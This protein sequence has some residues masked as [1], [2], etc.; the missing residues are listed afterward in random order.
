M[1]LILLVLVFAPSWSFQYWQGWACLAAFFVPAAAISVYVAR[2]DPALME[3]RVKTGPKAEQRIGQKVVQVTITIVFLADF[4]IPSLGHRFGWPTVSAFACILGD[5][6]IL[7][8]FAITF[9]VL[10]ENSYASG[11]IEV[12][13][14]QRVISTGPYSVVRHPMYTGGLIM[15]FGIPLALGS[16]RGMLVNIPMAA[17]IIWRLLDEEQ[18]LNMKLSGYAAYCEKVKYRLVPSIW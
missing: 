5:V 14:D 6:M 3:R 15:L 8:G 7:I 9:V 1:L 16:S 10:R 13:E 18:F 12:A 17:A 11:V 2:K 4:V